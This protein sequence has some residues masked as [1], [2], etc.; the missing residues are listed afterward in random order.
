MK[1]LA[2]ILVMLLGGVAARGQVVLHPL[3]QEV[4]QLPQHTTQLRKQTLAALSLPFFDDFANAG[5][6]PDL[7]HWQ[8]NGGV[9]INSRYAFEPL[10][11]NVASF[12]GLDAKGQPYAPGSVAAGPSDTL[13]S[14]PIQLGN[15]SPSDS[16]YL[17][18]YW[19]SG[20]LGDVPDKTA[21][22]LVYLQLE[23]KDASGNW[24]QVWRQPG[25]GQRSDFRQV[26]IGLKEARYFHEN[27]QFRFRSVGVRNG[28]ADVW[29]IDYVELDRNRRKGQ[30]TTRDIAISEG[31]S[32]LL[33]HYTAMPYKQFLQNPESE[34]APEVTATV[35]NLGGLPG[36]ISWRGYVQRLGSATADTFLRGQALVPGDARQYA[37]T[38]TPR[39]QNL[40]LPAAPFTL[41]HGIN[42]ITKET[43][44][45][46]RANDSTQRKTVFA[47]YFAYDDGSAEAGFSFVGT[48]NTQV[49]QRYTLQLPDQ[50]QAFRIYFPH[51]NQDLSNAG[52]TFKIWKDAKGVPG[53][54]LYQQNFKIQYSDT[55][56]E[57]YEVEL[58]KQ[59]AVYD[60]F[61]I[62]WSQPGNLFVNVGFD[63][64]ENATGQRLLFTG[65]KDWQPDTVT[66]GALM[67]RPVMTG[68]VLG[69][70]EDQEA[71][72]IK[73]YPNPA[74]NN[75]YIT[76][77]YQYLVLYDVTGKQV[78]QHTFR[79]TATPL[80]LGG[81]PP[82]LYT[83]RITTRKS[84]VTK[85]LILLNP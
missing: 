7:T 48:G 52:I 59:V 46:Q 3:Q 76:G 72:K 18:F 31:I 44:A 45:L 40:N 14:Q 56:N 79:D 80:Q 74:V 51:V 23:F 41:V 24:Q 16:V 50:V 84:I 60:T 10:T 70:K 57:F 54:L 42:L 2:L 6:L 29:N 64:N 13:T 36:A 82:G 34:L 37:I 26:F 63:R 11:K 27:F 78:Y 75:V 71:A 43:N 65:A 33:Q 32:R 5:V 85:K 9:Y 81:L 12:D 22:N 30:N 25:I 73:V 1:K 17:S 38:G 15:L 8:Q 55:L 67:L 68:N 69:I 58:N 28:L 77:E 47:D 39:V 66:V 35:N 49:A 53:E 62:G 83:L 20:G 4:R 19:Q 21:S 61:Y